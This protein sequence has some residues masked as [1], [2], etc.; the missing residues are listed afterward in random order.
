MPFSFAEVASD[1]AK[2]V[3]DTAMRMSFE[4]VMALL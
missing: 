1:S 4:G 2:K 3:S